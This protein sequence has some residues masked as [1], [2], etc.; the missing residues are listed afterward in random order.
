VWGA[1]SRF[2]PQV[3]IRGGVRRGGRGAR[4]GPSASA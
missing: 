1:Q 2:T 4:R 3:C